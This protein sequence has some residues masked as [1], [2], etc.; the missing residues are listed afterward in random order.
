MARGVR[1][2]AHLLATPLVPADYL[3]LL[4]PLNARSALRGRIISRHR[5]TP[6]ATTLEIRPG[7]SWQGHQPGQHVRVGVDV[8]GVRHWRTYSITSAPGGPTFTIT[9]K[10]VLGGKV[11]N[12]LNDRVR[13]GELIH[14]EQASGDF[15]PSDPPPAKVLLITAGSGITPILGMLRSGLAAATDVTWIHSDRFA[16]AVIAGAEVRAMDGLRFIERSTRTQP[17][18]TTADIVAAVPDWAERQTWACGP[19]ELLDSLSGHWAEHDLSDQLHLERFTP[20]ARPVIGEGGAV[21]FTEAAIDADAPA[22][23]SLLEIGEEA[24]VLMPSGCRMGICHGC[25]TPLSSGSVRDLRNGEL[26]TAPDG[27]VISIQ[28]CVTAAAGPCHLD[29]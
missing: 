15:A 13:I 11:S 29:R 7:R 26:I 28:T 4:D 19:A 20:P 23:R 18:L 24:G 6:D 5:E 22:D 2:L 12:H 9:P 3:D 10:R 17:R 16:E 1:R 21:H 27:D 25:L 8:N 14:L